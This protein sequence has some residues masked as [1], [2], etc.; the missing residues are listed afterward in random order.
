VIREWTLIIGIFVIVIFPESIGWWA[1]RFYDAGQKRGAKTAEVSIAGAK[2]TFA[3]S[4]NQIAALGAALKA[5]QDVQKAAAELKAASGS[6]AN[7]QRAQTIEQHAADVSSQLQATLAS[8]RTI[9]LKKDQV[10]QDAPGLATG[11]GRYGVVVSADKQNDLAAYEVEQLKKRHIGQAVIYERQ[12][13]LRTVAQFPNTDEAS[14]SL[15]HIHE[16]R[17]GAYVINL[18]KWCTN[19]SHSGRQIAGAPVLTCP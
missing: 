3:D 2:L 9:Q 19:P 6:P 13:F 18:D 14:Q 11:A 10:I 17:K 15:P 7:V 4:T 5:N 8:A 1:K 12:G 16:Y